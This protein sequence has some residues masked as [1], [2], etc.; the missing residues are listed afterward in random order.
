MKWE[1]VDWIWEREGL[2]FETSVI[3]PSGSPVVLV[4]PRM[5]W[6]S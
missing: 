3:S 5:M 6:A 4:L 2:V 1:K